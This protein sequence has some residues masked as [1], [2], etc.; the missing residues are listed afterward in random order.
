MKGVRAMSDY[1]NENQTRIDELKRN[2]RL[3]YEDWKELITTHTSEDAEY[4]AG[5]AREIA[6]R[7]FGKKIF[8][9]GIIEFTNICKNDCYYC[10]IRKSNSNL[11]RY[12]LTK[13]D[14]LECCREGQELGYRTFVLQGGEDGYFSDDILTDIVSEIRGRFP[15]CAIT[16]SVGERSRESYKRLKEAGADRYLL[17][18]ETADACHYGMLHPVEMSHEHR[19]QCLE[20]LR[21]LGFQTGCGMMVGS[22]YQTDELIAKDMVFLQNFKPE[23]VGMGPFI[24]HRQTPFK[25][26]KAGSVE[27]TLFLL[28]LVR[29]MKPDVLLPST[30]A[31]GSLNSDG[32]INGVL[33]GGNVVMPN[34][35]PLSVRKKYMLYEGKAGTE[36]GPKES[37]DAL[38]EQ[39]ES[40]GYVVS[41]ER[42]DWK[43]IEV[44]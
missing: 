30:T 4:A 20:N 8:F 38:K 27:L 13:E 29:I 40:I 1:K 2:G 9:R 5:I 36:L 43:E 39:M 28:S 31:L 37:L 32:R 7:I 18:H 3:E 33:A 19:M 42:G 34:L 35:S 15:D 23:M 44:G 26:M 14:I 17:R 16:L 12:R 24:P 25:D 6:T 10:G 11:S 22:P 41:S 21:G